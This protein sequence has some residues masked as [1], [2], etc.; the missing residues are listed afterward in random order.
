M[1]LPYSAH[2]GK[3]RTLDFAPLFDLIS[4]I[5]YFTGT[6]LQMPVSRTE[7]LSYQAYVT[8]FLRHQVSFV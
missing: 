5:D 4:C 7:Q 1:F 8:A 3:N 6:V 2:T